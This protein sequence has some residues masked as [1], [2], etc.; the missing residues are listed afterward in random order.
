MT[1]LVFPF[2]GTKEEEDL[3]PVGFKNILQSSSNTAY[4]QQKN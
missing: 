4:K 1:T 2:L 3:I